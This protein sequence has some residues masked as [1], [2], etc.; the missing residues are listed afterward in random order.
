[1]IVA[2]GPPGPV[3]AQ[4]IEG[5][6]V[7]ALGTQNVLVLMPGD[8][9]ELTGETL[10]QKT[11]VAVSQLQ[12]AINEQVELRTPVRLAWSVVKSLLVTTVFVLLL[13][14]LRRGYRVLVIRLPEGAEQHLQRLSSGDLQLVRASRAPDILRRFISSVTVLLGLVVT[15]SWFT[16]VLRQ[17][18]YTRPWGESAREFLLARFGAMGWRSCDRRQTVHRLVIILSLD[19]SGRLAPSVA[20]AEQE[21]GKIP[22]LRRLRHRP[23]GS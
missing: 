19:L 22:G 2:A 12:T 13:W 4:R 8:V 7:V 15:Y 1:M 23:A 16:F 11:A 18:P 9:D 21:R 20:A 5:V 17:F 6:M 14:G 10:E 3:T